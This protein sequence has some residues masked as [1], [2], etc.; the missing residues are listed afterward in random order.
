MNLKVR[1]PVHMLKFGSLFADGTFICSCLGVWGEPVRRWNRKTKR[2]KF[3]IH[4]L[5]FSNAV[6]NGKEQVEF[7]FETGNPPAPS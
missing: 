5:K 2:K 4:E 1:I 6:T 3:I 7:Y